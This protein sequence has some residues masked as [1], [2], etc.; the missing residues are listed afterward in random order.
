MLKVSP[1]GLTV[2]KILAALFVMEA[3]LFGAG[4][5]IS[6]GQQAASPPHE[7]G[8]WISSPGDPPFADSQRD[9]PRQVSVVYTNGDEPAI[10][11]NIACVQSVNSLRQPLKYEVDCDWRISPFQT[12]ILGHRKRNAFTLSAIFGIEKNVIDVHWWQKPGGVPF[13]TPN[14]N[15]SDV[16]KSILLRRPRFY[17]CDAWIEWR[18]TMN[19][20][21]IREILQRIADSVS[22]EIKSGR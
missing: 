20:P 22:D 17:V 9:D 15:V 16:V 13:P 7:I 19:G 1:L 18:P 11:V 4:N 2:T 10:H 21:H 14:N 6:R 12:G 5:L 8:G 3:A